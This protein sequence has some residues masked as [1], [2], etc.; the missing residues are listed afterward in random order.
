ML[1]VGFLFTYVAP[2]VLV[3]GFTLIKEFIDDKHRKRRDME[4]NEEKYTLISKTG[5]TSI[6]SREIKVGHVIEI[7]PNQRIPADMVVLN[8]SEEDG[9][10]FIK[11]DQLDGETDW[12]LRKSLSFTHQ[13]MKNNK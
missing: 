4:T 13:Y 8:T 7:G 2:L 6:L 11:T 1:K 10:V 5:R 12:K 9:T 3:L